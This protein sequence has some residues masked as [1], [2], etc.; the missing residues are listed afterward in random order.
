MPAPNSSDVIQVLVNSNG[1]APSEAEIIALR[2]M[3]LI[4]AHI[5]PTAATR[6]SWKS[7]SE[8]KEI[9]TRQFQENPI[10]ES[11]EQIVDYPTIGNKTIVVI[12]IIPRRRRPWWK[13]WESWFAPLG[14]IPGLK[15]FDGPRPTTSVRCQDPNCSCGRDIPIGGGYFHIAKEK[16][17]LLCAK[18]AK[19]RGIDLKVASA[20]AKYWWKT[21]RLPASRYTPV[22]RAASQCTDTTGT[23]KEEALTTVVVFATDVGAAKLARQS[24]SVVQRVPPKTMFQTADTQI[25]LGGALVTYMSNRSYEIEVA[26]EMSDAEWSAMLDK[27]F[28]GKKWD[29]WF[30]KTPNTIYSVVVV[31]G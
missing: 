16:I 4:P 1:T 12:T 21:G 28:A 29:R 23:S 17:E 30:G 13:F 18:A 6:F 11:L 19:R 2:K 3:G 7:M 22:T 9:Y 27:R 14:P 5:T 25:G 26:A 20:D 10:G 31:R 8:A 15:Y 24:G